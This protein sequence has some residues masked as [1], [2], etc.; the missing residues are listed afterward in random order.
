M[1]GLRLGLLPLLV[2]H[3]TEVGIMD[4]P[5]LKFPWFSS[6]NSR[7]SFKTCCM[8]VLKTR[9]QINNQFVTKN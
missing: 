1:L 4:R 2:R 7:I 6:S 3:R 5:S 8:V 9:A